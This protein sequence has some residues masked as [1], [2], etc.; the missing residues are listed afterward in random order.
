MKADKNKRATTKNQSILYIT[1][2]ISQKVIN[3]KGNNNQIKE[4]G[5]GD[6]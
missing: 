3:T 4:G 5:G 2:D 1:V 6:Q